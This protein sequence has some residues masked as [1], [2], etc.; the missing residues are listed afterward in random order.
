MLTADEV[1]AASLRAAARRKRQVLL[2][3]ETRLARLLSIVAPSLLD[4]VLAKST[5]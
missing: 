5:R 1:A 2:G 4:R 3:R